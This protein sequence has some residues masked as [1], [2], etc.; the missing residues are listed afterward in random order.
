MNPASE[1]NKSFRE[2][3]AKLTGLI[4]AKF[5]LVSGTVKVTSREVV[6][7][8]IVDGVVLVM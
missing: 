6:Y 5:S 2:F 7:D 8:V 4:G 3:C 1:E